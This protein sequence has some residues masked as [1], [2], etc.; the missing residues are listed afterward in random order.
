MK[1]LYTILF[2]IFALF[3]VVL[4]ASCNN[5]DE[6]D[7]LSAPTGVYAQANLTE[8]FLSWQPVSGAAG[9]KIYKYSKENTVQQPSSNNVTVIGGDNATIEKAT[10]LT[11]ITSTLYTVAKLLPGTT[12]YFWIKAY[13]YNGIESNYSE[14]VSV[15]TEKLSAPTGIHAEMTNTSVVLSW[16]PVSIATGYTIYGSAYSSI[17]EE[18]SRLA[19]TESTSVTLSTLISGKTYNFWVKAYIRN[20]YGANTESEYSE[21]VSV[22]T[23][24]SIPAP[25]G[26]RVVS[27]TADSIT[28]SWSPVSG[29]EYYSIYLS[30]DSDSE[31]AMFKSSTSSTV[32]TIANLTQQTTYYIWVK[33]ADRQRERY[34]DYSS[35]VSVT[36]DSGPTYLKIINS[37]SHTIWAP[38]ILYTADGQMKR[39]DILSRSSLNCLFEGKSDSYSFTPGT[40]VK[41]TSNKGLF[42]EDII[43]TT[44]DI[45]VKQ[46]ETT[47]VTITDADFKK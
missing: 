32:T 4:S 29:V 47:T 15:T 6:N 11:Q 20:S 18:S 14:V 26:V 35:C 27:K 44:R 23:E 45:V 34:S 38:V 8:V 39:I 30:E 43:S 2:S 3:I 25:T 37:S 12:Y 40:Y 28:L 10:Y 31:N 16:E 19:G 17:P 42:G 1:R 9:Y 22:T 36:T 46:G 41:I 7:T 24:F 21:S 33:A 13:S 5:D